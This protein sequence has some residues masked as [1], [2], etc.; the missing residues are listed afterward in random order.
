M[1]ARYLVRP[2]CCLLAATLVVRPAF[3]QEAP[4]GPSAFTT[5]ATP[6]SATGDALPAAAPARDWL[7]PSAVDLTGGGRT[8]PLRTLGRDF[9][10]FFGTTANWQILGATA[11]AALTASR[12]DGAGAAEAREHLPASR[13]S[14]GNTGGSLLVQGGGA[15]ATWALGRALGSP[16]L[17]AL[18]GDLVEAQL[19]TQTVVQAL[20]VSVQRP[21]PDGSNRLSFPSGHTASTF[22]TAS[23]LQRHY[24]W[25]AGVPAYAFAAYVGAARMA[26]DKHHLTDVLVGAG[27]GVVAGRAVT[28]GVGDHRFD[29]GV[30][31]TAGGAMVSF[32][33][34]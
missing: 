14:F 32:S 34:R 5:A 4:V 7:R 30:A 17:T 33:R 21:R 6:S 26:A 15:A 28:V 22:A 20:K 29:V 10:T 25:K 23:V 27:I 8:S 3:A 31:P 13:F 19:V 11:A 12:W 2:A 16:R 18:G 9:G 24:G 1:R